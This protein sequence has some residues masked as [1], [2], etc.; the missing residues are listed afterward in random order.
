MFN[1]CH[2]LKEIKG[3]NKFNTSKVTNMSTMFGK[4]NEIESINLSNYDTS[5]VTDK[6]YLFNECNKLK[7]IKGIDKFKTSKVTNMI[8]LFNLCNEIESINLSSFDTSNV[9]RQ[10]C[11]PC[12]G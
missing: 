5:N 3:I 9:T 6:S 4:C 7:E 11:Q 1:Q 12:C 8:A 2:K 10:D